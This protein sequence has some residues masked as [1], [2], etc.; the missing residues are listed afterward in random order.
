MPTEYSTAS[1]AIKVD[2]IGSFYYDLLTIR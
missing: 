1:F 2:F